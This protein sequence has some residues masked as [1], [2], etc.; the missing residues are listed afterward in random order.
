MSV[1]F[2]EEVGSSTNNVWR[3]KTRV[4]GLSR[5]VVCMILRFAVLIQYRL[6]THRQTDTHT[7]RKTDRQTHDDG[8]YPTVSGLL[9]NSNFGEKMMQSR[10]ICIFLTFQCGPEVVEN[11]CRVVRLQDMTTFN[12]SPDF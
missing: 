3:Q 2:R 6:V 11:C 1:N 7:D 9:D 8:Y 12:L 4:S 10:Y 5:G